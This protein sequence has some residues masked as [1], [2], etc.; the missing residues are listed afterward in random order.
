MNLDGDFTNHA[1]TTSVPPPKEGKQSVTDEVIKDMKFRR[2]MGTKK[3]GTELMT[4]NGRMALVDAYQEALD[5][6][7]YLKQL[8]ME[9]T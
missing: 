2:E 8:L 6:V 5:L 7:M 3:Y 4:F 9:I 1:D